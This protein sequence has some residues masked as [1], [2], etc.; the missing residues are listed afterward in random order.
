MFVYVVI[1]LIVADVR[2]TFSGKNNFINVQ[3]SQNI[4]LK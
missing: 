1:R 4:S 2:E 3:V